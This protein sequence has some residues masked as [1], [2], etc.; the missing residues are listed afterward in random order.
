M[1]DELHVSNVALIKEANL[2]LSP[3]LNVITGETGA[4]KTALLSALKLLAGER[5]EAS[6]VREGAKSLQVQGRI[7]LQRQS[8]IEFEDMSAVE[9][10]LV[11]SRGITSDGRSRVHMNGSISQVGRLSKIVGSSIDLCGQHEH[12]RLLKPSN[13]MAM[14]DAWMGD[15]VQSA[16]GS[17]RLAFEE[18]RAATQKMK[19]IEEAKNL[20]ADQVDQARY[21]LRRIDEVHPLPGEYEELCSV[22]PKAENAETLTHCAGGAHEALSGEGGVLETLAVAV[23]MLEQAESIDSDLGSMAASLREASYVIEDVS[24]DVRRY[25]DDIDYD[26][27]ALMDMEERMSQLQGLMRSWGP[28]LEEVL[29]ARDEAAR[30]IEMVDGFDHQMNLAQN[31]LD[32]AE[33]VL[34][35]RAEDLHSVR[36]AAAPHFAKAVTSQMSR[37]Q[38]GNASL[39]CLV[40]KSKRSA[41]TLDGPS[42]V[43]FMFR[44]G[45][46]LSARPLAKIA[47]GGEVSRVMLAI[48]VVLGETDQ[49]DTLVFDEVDAG[50]G[51][52]AARALA[53]VLLDL[54]KTHQVI[55]VTHLPQVAVMGSAH[56]IASKSGDEEPETT[57]MQVEGRDRIEEI[58]R[59]LSGDLTDA[60]LEHARQ[61]LEPTD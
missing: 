9:E 17:Y 35:Q 29:N 34:G 25:Q 38:L 43:E 32:K 46:R 59:M 27:S 31:E 52:S 44:P 36:L 56:F 16:L 45:E 53:D 60:S 58:A 33:E 4:G 30:T 26:G 40:A 12:Q 3:G 11:A 21:I 14:L 51:G 20:S 24:M 37:L 55:V 19:E 23:R 18:V 41:W 13:H 7:F 47:S 5:G 6:M 54:S 10:G 22:V 1:I 39:E 50:V 49:V 2:I 61:M 42:K 57:F 15:A 8:E 48:K 28:T